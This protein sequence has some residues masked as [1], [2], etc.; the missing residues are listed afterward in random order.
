MTILVNTRLL[1]AN[2][3]DGIGWFTYESLKRMTRD[4]PEVHF[5]F[6]F[7]RKP[8]EEFVF[9]GNVTPVVLF[10]PAR[11]PFLYYWW[12]QHSLKNL[13]KQ[14]KPDLFL[15]PDGFLPLDISCKT[16]A[17]I[18]D[19]NFEHYPRSLPFFYRK[20][21]RYYFP[22]FAKQASRIVTV[23]EF[24]KQDIVHQY[25]I[26]ST[27]IDVVYNGAND[28]FVPVS[29]E[30]KNQVKE[31][32][33]R[34]KDYFLFVGS[35]HQRK[36]IVRLFQAFDAFKQASASDFKL[37]IVGERYWADADI[38]AAFETMKY[39]EDVVFTGRLNTPNLHLVFA[40]AFALSYVPYF[41]GFGI[42]LVEAMQCGIPI[43]TSNCSSLPEIA[44]D[45]ALLVDPFSI[46]AISIGMVTLYNNAPLR[47]SL[48]K[49]GKARIQFFSW[50]KTAEKLWESIIQVLK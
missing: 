34:G 37:L 30:I 47:E 33:T 45:A 10:P 38:N 32:Y 18:H 2:R 31:K 9:S 20:Y 25:G 14:L 24:S 26:A 16:L 8:S 28:V 42:P 35:L 48:I 3:L 29:T 23:S 50:D 13:I 12:F 27:K 44:G 40:S 36:N 46:E 5:V 21:Y 19:L 43:L 1:I 39:K 17:V 22:K 11:H 49:K 7:D 6:A 41:E 4:H 15:S